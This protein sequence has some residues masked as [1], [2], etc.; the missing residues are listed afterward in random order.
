MSGA[1]FKLKMYPELKGKNHLMLLIGA[2]GARTCSMPSDC[3][4]SETSWYIMIAEKEGTEVAVS[5]VVLPA[6][7]DALC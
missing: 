6:N 4:R 5:W 1:S 7:P 2:S 3:R